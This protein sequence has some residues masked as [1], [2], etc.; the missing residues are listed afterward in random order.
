MGLFSFFGKRKQH[1]ELIDSGKIEPNIS[2]VFDTK[3]DAED[4]V[5]RMMTA[6]TFAGGAN[7]NYPRVSEIGNGKWV[8]AIFQIPK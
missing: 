4:F 3:E 7:Y 2:K 8:G 1:K 6:A 5:L